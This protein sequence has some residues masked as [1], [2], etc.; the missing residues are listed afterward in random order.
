MRDTSD[1][2][3]QLAEM[4]GQAGP[5]ESPAAVPPAGFADRVLARVAA[6]HLV[7]M[8]LRIEAERERVVAWAVGL[9]LAATLVLSLWSWP[10]W[11]LARGGPGGVFDPLVAGPTVDLLEP[12][13]WRSG[14][15][16]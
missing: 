4:A 16:W 6:N 15:F 11:Q 2:W 12:A 14:G 7:M 1:R 3:K 13:D 8:P 10:E 5:V 9:G